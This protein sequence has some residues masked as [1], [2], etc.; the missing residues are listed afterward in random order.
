MSIYLGD[1][2]WKEAEQLSKDGGVVVVPVS[3]L[4]QHGHHLP[5]DTDQRLVT[6]VTERSCQK[7]KSEKVP[8]VMTPAIWTGFSPHHMSFSGTITLE[9]DS[10]QAII[11]DV[12]VSLWKHGFRKILLLN[13]H[14]GNA[15]IL[16]AVVQ[17]LRFDSKVRAVTASYWDFAIP[18]MKEWRKSDIGGIN[19]ACEMETALMLHLA[20][21]LVNKDRCEKANWRPNSDY[22]TGDLTVGGVVSTA[23]DFKEVSEVGVVGD[24]SVATKEKGRVLFNE[25]TERIARFLKEFYEWNWEE[26]TSL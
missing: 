3:A 9:M 5:L 17:H 1:L 13:G 4:E 21:H 26:I 10:F 14:G 2:K 8:V 18:F 12:C 7:A 24:P 20:E 11:K 6:S 22:L 16:K 15:A 23:F 19:H 25:I